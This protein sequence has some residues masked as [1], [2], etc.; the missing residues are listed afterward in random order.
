MAGLSVKFENVAVGELVDNLAG[1][2]LGV[3]DDTTRASLEQASRD[4]ADGKNFTITR[5]NG[6][7]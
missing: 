6:K 1:V 7:S 2:D 3:S 4:A 5:T